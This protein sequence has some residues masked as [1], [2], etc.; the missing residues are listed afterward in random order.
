MNRLKIYKSWWEI[1]VIVAGVFGM[2][3][4]FDRYIDWRIDQ[5][6]SDEATLK[7]IG[8][9]AR[10][11]C[12]FDNK[13]SIHFDS[14]AMQ[15]IGY[16]GKSSIDFSDLAKNGM[17][18]HLTVHFNRL[19]DYPPAVTVIGQGLTTCTAKRGSGYDWVYTVYSA[20]AIVDSSSTSP[21]PS[22]EQDYKLEILF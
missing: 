14:G 20:D 3:V 4:G 11:F 13:G 22:D 15:F 5:K 21:P 16:P 1:V 9:S 10:P 17:P 18:Q 12:I 19:F 2:V 8:M 6:L 7:K